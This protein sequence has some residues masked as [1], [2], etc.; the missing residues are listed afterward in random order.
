ML[1]REISFPSGNKA[2]ISR[3]LLTLFVASTL[4]QTVRAND[5][6]TRG[7]KKPVMA[8]LSRRAAR[9]GE[10]V[11]L[12]VTVPSADHPKL[13][14]PSNIAG[15]RFQILRK[16]RVLSINGEKIWLFRY[17]VIP[18]QI[19]N[20]EI[21]PLRMIDGDDSRESNPMLLHVSK[22]G[23]TPPLSSRELAVGVGIPESLSEEILKAAPQPTPVPLAAS[24]PRDN[25]PLTARATSSAW[26]AL[27]SFWNYPGN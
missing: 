16:G 18:D 1:F 2:M 24:T 8:T 14:I 4:L 11:E 17:R 3:F 26:G 21:P 25:R 6:V 19:G 12:V 27:K 15:L 9:P 13:L 22:K 20:Y 5:S 10:S 7:G 23:E